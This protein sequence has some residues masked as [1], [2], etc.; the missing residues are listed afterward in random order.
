MMM[1]MIDDDDDDNDPCGSNR[2]RALQITG[3]IT[4][5]LQ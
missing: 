4:Q 3:E 2:G 5:S 1:M